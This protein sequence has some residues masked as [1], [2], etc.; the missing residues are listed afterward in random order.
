MSIITSATSDQYRGVLYGLALGDGIGAKY[1][2]GPLERLLWWFLSQSKLGKLRYSD[3]TLMAINLANSFLEMG[4][5]D[6]ESLAKEFAKSYQ[7]QRGYGPASAKLLKR[8]RN[9]KSWKSEVRRV[10]KSG[11]YGNGA[12]MRAPVIALFKPNDLD[13]LLDMTSKASEVTHAHP[14]AVEGAK[15]I[16]AATYFALQSL[17][18]KELLTRLVGIVES[19][20]FR[21]KLQAVDELLLQKN[22]A[23]TC[24]I[25]K[26]LGNNMTA[27]NSCG[28]AIY[29]GLAYRARPILDMIDTACA[30]RGD[31]DTIAAMAGAIW[32][33]CNGAT[34]IESDLLDKLEAS[35]QLEGLANSLV[36][37]SRQ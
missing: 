1:E 35:K 31:T 9:G 37:Q 22:I 6:Q 19:H 25:R 7:W 29:L 28:T 26:R 32:G 24:D 17:S 30:L 5:I 12:A 8:I 14:L 13:D 23:E 10:F 4:R 11:S 18:S 3:D 21:R 20:E 27:L 36:D 16:A 34:K 15:L 2:G 33:A